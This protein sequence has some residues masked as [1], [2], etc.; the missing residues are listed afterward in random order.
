ML[1]AGHTS[2]E[3]EPYNCMSVTAD[4]NGNVEGMISIFPKMTL[5]TENSDV[6]IN[7]TYNV[8]T[9]TYIDNKIAELMQ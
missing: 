8:D 7:C 3:Y 5:L 9:K 4:L 2:T 1:E 6:I